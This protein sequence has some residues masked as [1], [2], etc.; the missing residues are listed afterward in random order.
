MNTILDI[1]GGV[2]LVAGGFFCFTAAAAQVRFPD[3]LGRMHAATKPQVLGLLLSLGGVF[4]AKPSWEAFFFL[5][6]VVGLQLATAPISSHMVARTAYRSTEWDSDSAVR[7]ELRD[8][9][10]NSGVSEENLRTA[11]Q[12][13]SA[14]QAPEEETRE[15]GGTGYPK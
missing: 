7:D 15:A 9:V 3:V 12:N 6:L 5:T 10:L 1:A 4:L 13:A 2:L 14:V 8:E 11:L